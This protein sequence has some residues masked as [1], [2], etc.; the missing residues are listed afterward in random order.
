MRGE[1]SFF[2]FKERGNE[3]FRAL[4]V[5]FDAVSSL[6][7]RNLKVEAK[8]NRGESSNKAAAGSSKKKDNVAESDWEDIPFYLASILPC[9]VDPV[10]LRSLG[11]F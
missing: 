4:N 2:M 6:N 8:A 10:L 1:M 7:V 9:L 11:L 5:I 3:L